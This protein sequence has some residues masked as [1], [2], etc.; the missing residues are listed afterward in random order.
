ML[1][2]SGPT[3]SFQ[4]MKLL[5]I[6]VLGAVTGACV[7]WFGFSKTIQPLNNQLVA[8]D[9]F[10]GRASKVFVSTV[11]AEQLAR[12]ETARL[13][14]LTENARSNTEKAEWRELDESEIRKLEFRWSQNGSSIK[15]EFHN[16]FEKEVMIERVR[17]QIPPRGDHAA[18][19]REFQLDHAVCPPLSDGWDMLQPIKMSFDEFLEP[20]SAGVSSRSIVGS[21][22]PIRVLIRK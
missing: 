12:D 3:T 15:A 1:I 14:A 21:V 6:F 4:T 11:E 20:R 19:D 5:I 13:E 8:V 10:T 9:R 16:P 7:L 17:V 22:T 2:H 18:I